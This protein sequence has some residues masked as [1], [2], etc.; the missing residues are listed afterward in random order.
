MS[1][2]G[3]WTQIKDEL[4][5]ERQSV[6]YYFKLTGVARGRYMMTEDGPCFSG[7]SGFLTNDVTHWMP[8]DGNDLLPE[9]PRED[10]KMPTIV[11]EGKSHEVSAEVATLLQVV[12]EERDELKELLAEQLREVEDA[13]I[14]S[15]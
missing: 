3:K 12:S 4:P 14:H 8:D 15:G 7:M 10:I 6:I 11:F 5:K 1:E 13:K 9:P 2:F